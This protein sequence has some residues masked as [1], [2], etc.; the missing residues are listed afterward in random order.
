VSGAVVRE[1][2][3]LRITRLTV[4]DAPFILGLLNDPDFLRYIGDRGVRTLDEA[5]AYLTSGPLA[6]YARHG[7][8]L[9]LVSLGDT[10]VPIGIS[11]VLRRDTLP[12][13]DIGFAFLPGFR[14]QGY[15]LEAARAVLDHAVRD[16]GLGRIVAIVSPDNEA[17]RRLL[18]VLGFRGEGR[19][20]LAEGADEV[21]LFGFAPV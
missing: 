1:T 18:G 4:E 19:I 14:R 21:D 15:A 12:D 7:F 20:R 9:Y 13:P 6:S 17:S 10:G 8:G 3:R 11:G 16:L 5:A 2:A